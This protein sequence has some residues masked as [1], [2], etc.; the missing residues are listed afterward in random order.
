[1][2]EQERCDMTQKKIHESK[3]LYAALGKFIISFAEIEHWLTCLLGVLTDDDENIW[4]T[5]MALSSP[6]SYLS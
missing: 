3:E 6:S 1:M 2:F 4:L 5:R